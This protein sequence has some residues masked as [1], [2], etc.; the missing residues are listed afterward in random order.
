MLVVIKS[1]QFRLYSL[2]SCCGTVLTNTSG[3]QINGKHGINCFIAVS[4]SCFDYAV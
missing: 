1:Q 2:L 3:L 4:H